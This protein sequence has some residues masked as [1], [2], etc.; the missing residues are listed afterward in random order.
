MLRLSDNNIEVV[1]VTPLEGVSTLTHL[2]LS[3]NWITAIPDRLFAGLPQL[4]QLWLQENRI[5]AISAGSFQNLSNLVLLS[6]VTNFITSMSATAITGLGSLTTLHYQQDNV[7]LTNP[8][9]CSRAVGNNFFQPF[10]C[11]GCIDDFVELGGQCYSAPTSSPTFTRAPNPTPTMAPT[12][13]PTAPTAAPSTGAPTPSSAPTTY[14]GIVIGGSPNTNRSDTGGSSSGGDDDDNGLSSGSVIGLIIAVV[15]V[16]ALIGY[17]ITH[18]RAKPEPPVDPVAYMYNEDADPGA[19][20]IITGNAKPRTSSMRLSSPA[21][22]RRHT[23]PGELSHQVH[24]QYLN[25][26]G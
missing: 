7:L 19:L 1:D 10:T 3:K 4:T 2:S 13:A 16:L 21:G 6:L 26:S 25:I 8:V 12:I 18:Q 11:S 17:L 14:H 22:G 15:L 23:E 20:K 5:T 9:R 24:D